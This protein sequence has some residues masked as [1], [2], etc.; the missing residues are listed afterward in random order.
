MGVM[1]LLSMQLEQASQS[2]KRT[3][4]R[5]HVEAGLLPPDYLRRISGNLTS[6]ESETTSEEE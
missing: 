3:L 6:E 5:N 2:R 4:I 1:K